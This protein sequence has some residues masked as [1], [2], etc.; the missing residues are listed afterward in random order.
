M[1][2]WKE[3]QG[4]PPREFEGCGATRLVGW[5]AT[6]AYIRLGLPWTPDLTT[7]VGFGIDLVIG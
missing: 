4:P 6:G 2:L 1:W 3:L 5:S 7:F